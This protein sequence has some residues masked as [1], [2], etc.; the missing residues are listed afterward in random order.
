MRSIYQE[1]HLGK[2]SEE[3]LRNL[4]DKQKDYDPYS[5]QPVAGEYVARDKKP[6]GAPI[7]TRLE[8]IDV[9]WVKQ[10]LRDVIIG[11]KKNNTNSI[12]EID[13]KNQEVFSFKSGDGGDYISPAD[14]LVAYREYPP[15]TVMEASA[16]L[17]YLL[18][19]LQDKSKM[20]RVSVMS[21]II[22]YE[23]AK[24]TH[25]DP[26]PGLIIREGVYQVDGNGKLH[27][28]PMA[29]TANS[30]RVFPAARRWIIGQDRDC[31]YYDA[32]ELLQVC[33]VLG[34]DLTEE[35]PTTFTQEFI[36]NLKVTYIAKNRNYLKGK[37]AVNSSVL[38]S[39]SSIQVTSTAQ[40]SP[41]VY[42]RVSAV[43]D[44]M[45]L[46]LDYPPKGMGSGEAANPSLFENLFQAY[47]EYMGTTPICYQNL[48]SRDG[49]L[50][51]RKSQDIPLQ[52]IVKGVL[53]TPEPP[54]GMQTVAAILHTSGYAFFIG[55]VPCKVY[56]PITNLAH[57]YRDAVA[58][59]KDQEFG[60]WASC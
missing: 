30:G 29:D 57:Y 18:K 10:Y 7:L 22:A 19:R 2:Y 9:T 48:V 36:D 47:A 59:N 46:A 39:L 12:R 32:L 49:F 55:K 24:L 42:T 43:E 44:T 16:K 1:Q 4:I 13:A 45:Q 38:N 28:T 54:S 41:S 17:P 8:D 31:Y 25:T 33:K 60:V 50:Y 37:I 56:I 27:L 51:L 58:E 21:L 20:L 23:R 14:Q 6:A 11:I 52:I 5:Q 26:K 40:S 15:T 3:D 53:L 34:I 35:D